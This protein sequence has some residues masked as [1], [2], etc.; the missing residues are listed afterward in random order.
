MLDA[1]EREDVR[2]GMRVLVDEA[3]LA[4]DYEAI[5]TPRLGDAHPAGRSP[6]VVLV[7]SGLLVIAVGALTFLFSGSQVGPEP[8][9]PALDSTPMEPLPALSPGEFPL[10]SIDLPGWTI[11]YVEESEGSIEMSDVED[12]AL[13]RMVFE[14]SVNYHSATILFT[15][16]TKQAE[17]RLSSSALDDVERLIADRLSSG[18]RLTDETVLGSNAAVIRLDDLSFT[19]IWSASDVEYEFVGHEFGGEDGEEDFRSVL[20]ALRRVSETDWTAS[21]SDE[22][23]SDRAST[24]R[25]YLSDIPLPPGF[26]T[27]AVEEGP[28]E[29]WYQV[30]ADTVR[31]VS[32]GWLDYWVSAKSAG[33]QASMQQAVDAMAGSRQWSILIDMSAEGGF[34]EMVWEYADAIATDGTVSGGYESADVLTV[35][36]SYTNAFGCKTS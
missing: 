12:T 34:H 1:K 10:V 15:D 36:G 26:D 8:S 2:R 14:E 19:G 5:I 21:L 6:L 23:V 29:H 31:A 11:S 4:P 33:D 17:L 22:I 16:G 35:E 3:P 20:R 24:I 27:T 30:G 25:Q 18:S 28:I 9:T 13:E 7:A 32:C